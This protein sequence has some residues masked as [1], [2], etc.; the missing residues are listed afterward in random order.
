M[1]PTRLLLSF[2]GRIARGTFW[3]G[4]LLLA[5]GY[6]VLYVYLRAEVSAAA[7]L[8]LLPVLFWIAAALAVKRLH[9]RGRSPWALLVA[10]IP[11]LGPLWLAV[12]LGLR[13]G[14]PGENHYGA[15]PLERDAGYLIVDVSRR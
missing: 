10:L 8:L 7:T 15:D 3:G 14:T 13:R 1:K 4:A 2:R 5:F 12:E 6:S 9:D 11:I